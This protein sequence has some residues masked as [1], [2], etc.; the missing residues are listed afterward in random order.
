[1]YN[2]CNTDS[3]NWSSGRLVFGTNVSLITFCKLE[4][5]ITYGHGRQMVNQGEDRTL[6]VAKALLMSS[7]SEFSS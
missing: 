6:V 3:C 7:V 5:R 4:C 1:M 2:A